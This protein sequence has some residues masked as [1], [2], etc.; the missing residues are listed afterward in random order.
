MKKVIFALIALASCTSNGN[1]YGQLQKV[2]EK[3]M[4]TNY[5]VI[6]M[7]FTGG[8]M[9]S[10]GKDASY[11]NTQ[12]F[13]IDKAAFDTLQGHLGDNIIVEYVDRGITMIAPSKL[14]KSIRI[15]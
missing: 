11:E 6:E 4:P 14:V 8:R 2:S 9:V 12:E 13:E 3:T 15:K 1:K 10:D 7:S 5:Y